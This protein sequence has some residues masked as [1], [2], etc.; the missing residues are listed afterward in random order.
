MTMTMAV[1]LMNLLA[2]LISTDESAKRGKNQAKNLYMDIPIVNCSLA[3]DDAN[4]NTFILE[5]N[6]ALYMGDRITNVLL[7]PNQ[8]ESNGIRIDLRSTHFYPHIEG[9]STINCNDQ[10][11]IP[12]LHDGP[13]PYFDVRHPTQNELLHCEKIVLTPIEEWNPYDVDYMSQSSLNVMSSLNENA[14]IETCH[15]SDELLSVHQYQRIL[16]TCNV[17]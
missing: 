12:I 9:A 5:I 13:L 4:G 11:I 2:G 3:Y 6:N 16:S 7:C 14:V 10:L 1:Q 17:Q 8:C 15:I